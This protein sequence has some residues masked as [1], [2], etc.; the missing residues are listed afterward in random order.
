MVPSHF[1]SFIPLGFYPKFILYAIQKNYGSKVMI[2]LIILSLVVISPVPFFY[3][4]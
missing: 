4:D 2:N 3:I 1:E